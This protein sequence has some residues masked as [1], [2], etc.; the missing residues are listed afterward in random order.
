[1]VS[2][3]YDSYGNIKQ[4]SGD[5]SLGNLNPFRYKGYYYDN[6]SGMYYCK[7]R[8]YVEYWLIWLNMDRI[9]YLDNTNIGN[10]NLFSYCN[11]NP[12]MMIDDKGNF[13]FSALIIGALVGAEVGAGTSAISQGI[14]NGWKNINGYQVLFDAGCGA[15]SGALSA[16]GIGRI[17]SAIASGIIG[18]GGSV[19]SDL[20]A[21][22]GKM[23]SIN[24]GKAIIMGSINA[25]I[26]YLLGAGSQNST[27]VGKEL[28]KNKEVNKTFGVLYTAINKNISG[29]MSNRGLAGVFN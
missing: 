28:I 22:G 15:I 9:E 12:V 18:F 11:N 20:I 14:T 13:F 21:S 24:W 4:I 26:G 23:N 16:S 25:G 27:E 7:S 10:I 2:Y 5:L 8:Y 6:E 17:G 29:E 3:K 1:M 19:G